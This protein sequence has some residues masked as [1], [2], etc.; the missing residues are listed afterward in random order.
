MG[1]SQETYNKKEVRN[2]KEKK[3]KDKL[4]KRANKKSEGKSNPDDMI[5]YVDQYGQITSSPPDPDKKIEVAADS[6]ELDITKGRS[7]EPQDFIRRGVIINWN[8]SKGYGFIRDLE[9]NR[10]IFFHANSLEE[11]VKENNMVTFEIGKGMKGPAAMK[12][13]LLKE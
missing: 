6:I 10:S 8:D 11:P 3:R 2:R 12:V 4:Q 7:A 13:K 5:A 9:S 1:R